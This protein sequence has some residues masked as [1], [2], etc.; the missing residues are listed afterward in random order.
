MSSPEWGQPSRQ[1]DFSDSA[2]VFFF[3]FGGECE[4][5]ET[6][7]KKFDGPSD[8]KG[9]Y[10]DWN[11]IEEFLILSNSSSSVPCYGDQDALEVEVL[12]DQWS[13]GG[14]FCRQRQRSYA[15]RWNDISELLVPSSDDST[16]DSDDDYAEMLRLMEQLPCDAD[17]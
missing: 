11:N 6:R 12:H 17:L 9:S 13:K 8:A 1:V 7:V 10:V 4:R 2:T 16:T 15:R 3:E 5:R 14:A